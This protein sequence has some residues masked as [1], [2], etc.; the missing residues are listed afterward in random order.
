MISDCAIYPPESYI[1]RFGLISSSVL[2]N[3]NSFCMLCYKKTVFKNTDLDYSTFDKVAYFISAVASI[4]L[5]IVGSVNEVE[6]SKLHGAAAVTFFAGYLIYMIMVVVRLWQNSNHSSISLRIKVLLTIVGTVCLLAFALMSTNWS[7][8]HTYIA[9][10]EWLGTFSIIVGLFSFVLEYGTTLN[11]GAL[12][13]SVDSDRE[14][15]PSF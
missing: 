15:L 8:Y 4:G 10:V 7:K 12:L 2:L 13:Q 11:L 14:L 1:F 3:V 6:N 5:G 9:V